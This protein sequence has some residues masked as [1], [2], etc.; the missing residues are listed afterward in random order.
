MRLGN[1]VFGIVALRTMQATVLAALLHWGLGW[2]LAGP[3][4]LG[5]FLTPALCLYFVFVFVA[6]WSWGLPILT[7]LKTR[8]KVA[9]LT[10]D[11]GPSETT[12]PTLDILSKFGVTATFFVLGESVERR[13]E[14]IR[15]LV[16]EGHTVGIHAWRHRAFVGLGRRR[17]EEEIRRTQAAVQSACP[18]MTAAQWLRPPHGFKSVR[19]LWIARKQGLRLAAWSID[20]R[21][22]R[23]HSPKRIAGCVLEKVRPGAIVLLHDGPENEATLG[24]LPLILVGLRKRGFRC[25]PLPSAARVQ[26]AKSS[27]E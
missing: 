3:R 9:A 4:A 6:P 1:P 13:P 7:R 12:G 14:L 26:A 15:R 24:A 20:S 27:A 22:Y 11:D 10:F 23:Q 18:E 8:E 2:P 21:D 17:I 25:I 5:L 16:L 19:A